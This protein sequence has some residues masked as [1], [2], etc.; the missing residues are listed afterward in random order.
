MDEIQRHGEF[1]DPTDLTVDH[2]RYAYD[3]T[4]RQNDPLRRLCLMIRCKRIPIGQSINDLKF[5]ALMEE[6]GPLVRDMMQMSWKLTL[7]QREQMKIQLRD[8]DQQLET[9]RKQ[10]ESLSRTHERAVKIHE[11]RPENFEDRIEEYERQL[12]KYRG[13]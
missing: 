13:F 3:N 8:K 9:T 4:V 12:R 5:I 1:C 2:I 11:N 6:G 10:L 7:K